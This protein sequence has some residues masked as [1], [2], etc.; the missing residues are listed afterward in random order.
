MCSA[1]VNENLPERAY[2][3]IDA[4][5][6]KGR[7]NT[8]FQGLESSPIVYSGQ[9]VTANN[10]VATLQDNKVATLQPGL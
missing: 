9:R 10:K 2:I 7:V 3:R 4:A 6:M 8:P 5:A 1:F